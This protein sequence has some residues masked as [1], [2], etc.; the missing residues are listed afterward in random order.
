MLI[1]FSDGNRYAGTSP[2]RN[3]YVRDSLD[4][5]DIYDVAVPNCSPPLSGLADLVTQLNGDRDLY[6][7]IKRGESSG[8][9]LSACRSV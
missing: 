9:N 6:T 3:V 5:D 8:C 4:A 7:F 1:D 2:K